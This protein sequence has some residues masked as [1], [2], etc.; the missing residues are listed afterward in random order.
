MSEKN[1]TNDIVEILWQFL[2]VMTIIVTF[3]SA[4]NISS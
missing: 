4:T 3:S 2:A 1:Q